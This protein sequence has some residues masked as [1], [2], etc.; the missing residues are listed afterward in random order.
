MVARFSLPIPFL[1]ELCS[2]LRG[3]LRIDGHQLTTVTAKGSSLIFSSAGFTL[4]AGSSPVDSS[5]VI[6]LAFPASTLN[7][8]AASC[9]L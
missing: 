1:L 6:A 3:L 5:T 4:W 8:D 9:V 7:P 2:L